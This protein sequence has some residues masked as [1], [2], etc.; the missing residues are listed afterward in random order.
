MKKLVMA[1]AIVVALGAIGFYSWNSLGGDFSSSPDDLLERMQKNMANVDSLYFTGSISLEGKLGT[2]FIPKSD[3]LPT[4]DDIGTEKEGQVMIDMT[5]VFGIED[6]DAKGMMDIAIG[7]QSDD[8]SGDGILSMRMIGE[9]SYMKVDSMDI[10]VGEDMQPMM[11]ALLQVVKGRWIDTSIT[12]YDEDVDVVDET[13]DTASDTEFDVLF[14]QLSLL[15][16]M[17]RVGIEDIRGVKT[18]HMTAKIDRRDMKENKSYMNSVLDTLDGM[19]IDMWIGS[20]DALLYKIDM[21]G[22]VI[23]TEHVTE[24]KVDFTMEMY[25]YHKKI[26]VEKPSE[27]ILFDELI[28]QVIGVMMVNMVDDIDTNIMMETES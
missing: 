6:E 16:D 25:D 24:G 21:S 15:E 8:T 3:F 28:G 19:D 23:N 9:E 27:P 7:Y 17:R 12:R 10:P 22:P 11:D 1:I 13:Q 18:I 20:K 14:T 4:E 5:G 26:M 2:G